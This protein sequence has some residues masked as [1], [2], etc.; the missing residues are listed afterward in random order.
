MKNYPL[1]INGKKVT[2]RT[3]ESVL[4]KA[5][6]EP[7]A[8]ICIAGSKEVTAAVDAAEVAFASVKLSP[9]QRYEIIMKAASLMMDRQKEFAENLCREAGKPIK[10]AMGEIARA[11]QT[12]I[13]SAEEA[14]R[15]TG[16]MIPIQGAPGCEKRIAYTKRLPLGVVAAITP[17]NFPVNLACHKIGPALA[18]GDTVVYKPATATP[19]T[20]AMLC[21]VFAEAGLPAGCLNL[22]LGRGGAIGKLLTADQ[23]IKMFSF[24]G[25]V[26]V[27]KTLQ[28]EAGFRRVALELGSN[29]ANIVHKDVKE[30]DIP[31]IAAMC[32]KYAYTNAGQVC[33][34]C[35]RVYVQKKIYKKFCKAAVKFTKTLTVG[36]P[37]DPKTDIGPMI[38]EKEARR[39]E[40]WVKA[41]KKAGAKVLVGG[42]RQGSYYLPTV[43]TGTKDQMEVICKE[44]FAPVFSIMPY[45]D[46]EEAIAEVN[47]SHYGLQ[48][49][50]FTTSLEVAHLCADKIETGGVI[51]NDGSTFRM[52]N[53][54][55]GGVKDSGIGKEGPEYAVRE[56]TQEKLIVLNFGL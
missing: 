43:L 38:E 9:Y 2:T 41:A 8:T 4:N 13:L 6:G 33:I 1:F 47:N 21:E 27:G 54:P 7:F 19:I 55:Y 14:K 37:L 17:F 45:E 39:I 40:D 22:V 31:K 46:I 15:L 30:K 52:D 29:S 53:M 34:S 44:T 18:V 23:R 49:G 26:P 12:L 3:K 48:A 32:A 10:D 16:E 51:I 36:D 11:Y 5:T 20:G 25:S 24:T 42:K 28:A 35:Q 56:L 50:V